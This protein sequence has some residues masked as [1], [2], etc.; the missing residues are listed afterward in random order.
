[1]ALVLL[2]AVGGDGFAGKVAFESSATGSVIDAGTETPTRFLAKFDLPEYLGEAE[3]ELAVVEFSAVVECDASV[4]GLTLNAFL[5]TEDWEEGLID[6]TGFDGS[7][8]E[9]FD[10]SLHAMWG[11]AAGDSSLVRLDVTEMVAVWAG[12]A[13]ANRGFVLAPSAGEE[14]NVLPEFAQGPRAGVAALTIWYTPRAM[15]GEHDEENR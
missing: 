5:V 7:G 15:G 9:P 6:W 8:A 3:I 13:A 14:G 1:M 12:D 10:R 4:G 2:C 11:M